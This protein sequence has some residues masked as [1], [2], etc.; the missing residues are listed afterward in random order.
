MSKPRVLCML[1]L[2]TASEGFQ[3]LRETAD[4]VIEPPD[5]S[6]LIELI[7]QFDVL[8]GHV[9]LKVDRD[10]LDRAPKLKVIN[11]ASTGTDHIDKQAAA[12][13]GIRVLSI[14]TDYGLLD[15]FTA[16]AECAWTL[17][18][19]SMRHLRPATQHVLEGGWEMGR[20]VGQQ[21]SDSTLGVLGVGR[22]GRMVCQYGQAFRARVLGC[23]LKPFNE[24]GVEAVDFHTLLAESDAIS[25]HIHMLPENYHL[26]DATTLSK[27]KRGAVLVNTS[28]GDLIDETALMAALDSGQLSS[29]AADVLHD[30][31][32]TDMG[33]SPLVTYAQT[34]D[35]VII[36]PHM[37]GATQKSIDEA[38]DFSARK[39]ANFLQTGEELTWP[40]GIDPLW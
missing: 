35:N 25:I 8:W 30:E 34:H 14:T 13:R 29:F 15:R 16:T 9:D 37:G 17:L 38:R 32:R 1:P 3:R 36:S 21:L 10:V 39:L 18:L 26:F 20:F 2:D 19:A 12:D 23:D 6:R 31:W 11:T 40:T 4:I 24:P 28:R 22:L 5:R 27:M 7:E 33:K